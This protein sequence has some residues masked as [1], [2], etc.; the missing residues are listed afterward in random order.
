MKHA[1]YKSI[2]LIL[3]CLILSSCG[4][5][6]DEALNESMDSSSPGKSHESLAGPVK[7]GSVS[8]LSG[9]TKYDDLCHYIHIKTAQLL[10]E[11]FGVD[12]ASD[13]LLDDVAVTQ[14]LDL[15]SDAPVSIVDVDLVEINE[16]SGGTVTIAI[17]SSQEKRALVKCNIRVRSINTGETRSSEGVGRS[18][19][20]AWGIV[21][22]VD[23]KSMASQKGIWKLDN[24]M[25]G[26][27]CIRALKVHTQWSPF[28]PQT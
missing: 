10:T 3:I 12:V 28:C 15:T 1:F 5:I 6:V 17:F 26:I 21:A 11:N 20:G 8:N 13:E 22:K 4:G 2:S 24:S 19:K 18:A 9:K 27:A 25:L 23:R 14:D 7:I 16:R